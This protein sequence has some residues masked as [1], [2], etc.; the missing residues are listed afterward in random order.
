VKLKLLTIFTSL[1]LLPSS[2][3]T[4]LDLASLG[5]GNDYKTDPYIHAAADLQAMGREAACQA[6]LEFS[7]TNHGQ[8]QI[9][10]IVLCRMLF[11]QRGTNEFRPAIELY[12]S[13]AG[14]TSKQDW[15]LFPIEIVDGIP[16]EVRYGGAGGSGGAGP[17][18]GVFELRYCMTNLDWNTFKFHEPTAEEKQNALHKLISS[19]KWKRTLNTSELDFLSKQIE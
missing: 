13:G 14:L 3:A 2:Y 19:N 17:P 11:T 10:V 9:P 15:P 18:D 4:P 12:S 7:Q 5:Y 1:A 6:L 8:R 16:F